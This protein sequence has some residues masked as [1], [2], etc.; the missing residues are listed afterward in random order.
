MTASPIPGKGFRSGRHQSAAWFAAV[1][2]NLPAAFVRTTLEGHILLANGNARNMLGCALPT[3][4][5]TGENFTQH[6][7]VPKERGRFATDVVKGF[8]K[9]AFVPVRLKPLG[10][11]AS[12]P[13]RVLATALFDEDGVCEFL[14]HLLFPE[15]AFE[16]GSPPL[17]LL[18]LDAEQ[19]IVAMNTASL[20]LLRLTPK[21]MIGRKL[22]ELLSSP[23]AEGVDRA[24][25]E[26]RTGPPVPFDVHFE[27]FAPNR[28]PLQACFIPPDPHTS[29]FSLALT[30]KQEE[31]EPLLRE[32]FA[33]AREMAGAISHHLNQ[34]LTVIANLVDKLLND[35]P[36]FHPCYE[37]VRQ[38]RYENGGLNELVAR[39]GKITSYSATDYLQGESII[40]LKDTP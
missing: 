4:G 3:P 8:R 14:D 5:R 10:S 34:R 1:V 7:P 12:I 23:S 40:N 17:A 36:S 39:I 31:E 32:R 2:E 13:L 35:L 37:T 9:G 11:D 24:V 22:A 19:R 29:R 38:L 15:D 18:E 30:E 6:F 33:G 16:A 27:H 20:K 28:R 26:S 21:D 25:T